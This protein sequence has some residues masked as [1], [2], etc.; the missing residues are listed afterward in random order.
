VSFIILGLC[1]FCITKDSG[2]RHFL[3]SELGYRFA[4]GCVRVL[5]LMWVI[6]TWKSYVFVCDVF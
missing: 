5:R 6:P 2:K 1:G 3:R 4:S